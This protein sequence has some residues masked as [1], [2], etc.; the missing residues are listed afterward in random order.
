MTRPPVR[1]EAPKGPVQPASSPRPVSWV[2]TAIIVGWLIAYNAVRIAGDSPHRAAVIAIAPG[3]AL[4][5]ILIGLSVLGRRALTRRGRLPMRR[6]EP[7]G[8]DVLDAQRRPVLRPAVPFIGLGAAVSVAV[9]I[10]LAADW[11]HLTAADR[12]STKL[13]LALWDIVVGVW[14]AAEL[15]HLLHGHGDGLD[16]IALGSVLTAVLG[17]VALSRS[18]FP[19]VQVVLIVVLGVAAV[20]CQVVIWR[21]NGSRA[22]IVGAVLCAVL[23]VLAVV[24]PLASG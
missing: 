11:I 3:V 18:M 20:A 6:A 1:K 10:V 21:L 13:A 14:L 12:S 19:P 15:A 24:I 16:S 2:I 7:I 17:G 22:A 8:P 5:L 4:G 9:G 23:A